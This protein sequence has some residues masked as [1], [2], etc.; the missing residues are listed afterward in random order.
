MPRSP[1]AQFSQEEII[2]PN[3]TEFRQKLLD[4]ADVTPALRVSYQEEL[5]RMLHPQLTARS[6]SFGLTLLV[7]LVICTIGIVRNMFVYEVN[8]LTLTGW[9]I[10]AISFS[11]CSYLIVCDLLGRKHS[12]KS[13]STI[14]QTVYFA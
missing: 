6:A 1:S 3:P 7:V 11:Y 2:M 8:L 9:M 14:A 4:A 5:D 13:M 12:S 10:L